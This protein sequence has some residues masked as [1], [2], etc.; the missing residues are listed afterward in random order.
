MICKWG[1]IKYM[2]VYMGVRIYVISRLRVACFQKS[3]HFCSSYMTITFLHYKSFWQPEG[4]R[5]LKLFRLFLPIQKKKSKKQDEITYQRRDYIAN[6]NGW[7]LT[8][9]IMT[10]W[11]VRLSMLIH[12]GIKWWCRKR[13]TGPGQIRVFCALHDE[14]RQAARITGAEALKEADIKN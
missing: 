5:C 10:P 12:H 7:L 2:F 11:Q 9:D 6:H 1:S 8:K 4:Q 3:G 14:E 13:R